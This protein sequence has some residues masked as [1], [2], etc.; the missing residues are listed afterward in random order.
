VRPDQGVIFSKIRSQ[1]PLAF[2][3]AVADESDSRSLANALDEGANA[4]LFSSVSSNDFVSSLQAVTNGRFVLIDARLWSQELQPRSEERLSPPLHDDI[5]LDVVVD[6]TFALKQLSSR[7]LAILER[8]VRGDSNKQVARFFEIAEPTVKA[9]VKAIFTKIGASNRT[10]A[11]IWALS[12]RLVD[13]SDSTPRE[14]PALI[15][16][17]SAR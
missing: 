7:E 17:G 11:A 5:V 15:D 16:N 10:Q 6:E 2:V 1:Y 14:L 12:H 8:I 13:G 4:A 9:H 3:V